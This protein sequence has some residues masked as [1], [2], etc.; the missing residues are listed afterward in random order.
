MLFHNILYNYFSNISP[1]YVL[2]R[3]SA[4]GIPHGP[5]RGQAILA[6]NFGAANPVAPDPTHRQVCSF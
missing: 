3:K 1:F 6:D 2:T 4:P 5:L